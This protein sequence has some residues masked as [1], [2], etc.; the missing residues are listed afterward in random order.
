MAPETGEDVKML[1]KAL[2]A[3]NFEARFVN[4]R[5]EY[6]VYPA[7]GKYAFSEEIN[8]NAVIDLDP[9]VKYPTRCYQAASLLFLRVLEGASGSQAEELID[10][11]E[12]LLVKSS[13]SL[14]L[15]G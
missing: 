13:N 9:E 2:E 15:T 1:L 11:I 8:E 3:N 4:K 10:G 12:V 14:L 5:S 6:H 7:E